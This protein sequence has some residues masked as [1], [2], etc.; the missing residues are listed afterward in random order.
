MIPLDVF[1]VLPDNVSQSLPQTNGFLRSYVEYACACSDAPP[2]FHA[3]VAL[4]VFSSIVAKDVICPWHAGR[5]LLPNLYTLIVGPS[6]TARKTTAMDAGT[7]VLYDTDASIMMPIPGSYE[8]LVAQLRRQA[9]GLLTF[10]EFGHFLKQT[11]RGYAEPQRTALMDLYDWPHNRPYSRNLKKAVT[12]I[13]GP[14]CLSILGSISNELLFQYVDSAEWLGGF[15]GRMLLLYGERDEFKMPLEWRRAHTYLVAYLRQ[16]AQYKIPS[17][18]GFQT[19]GWAWFSEWCKIRDTSRHLLPTRVKNFAAG[20]T[21]FAAKI[22]LL[23]AI[24]SGEVLTGEGWL[25]SGESLYRATQFIDNL[26]LV[27]ALELGE[28]IQLSDWERYRQ[29][30]LD[31]ID[32]A[33]DLGIAHKELLRRT[34]VLSDQ[35]REIVETLRDEDTIEIVQGTDGGSVYRRKRWEKI[36]PTGLPHPSEFKR[37]RDG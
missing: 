5:S 20:V 23:F 16:Y 27:S 17:C 26:Y 18:G 22:A 15:F 14:I 10:R 30:A 21:T 33:G 3:G 37:A 28:R 32:A 36:E 2:V 7:D 31:Q 29:K 4:T 12:V 13:S 1:P 6:R 8:E 19:D 25:V 9:H 35:L 24:D 11:S 34:R